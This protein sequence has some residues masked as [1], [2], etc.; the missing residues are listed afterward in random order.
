MRRLRVALRVEQ[1]NW[2]A[3]LEIK[4][5]SQFDTRHLEIALS[6]LWV[7]VHT[8]LGLAAMSLD[9]QWHYFRAAQFIPAW[10]G[11]DLGYLG[12]GTEALVHLGDSF[13]PIDKPDDARLAWEK[14]AREPRGPL[15]SLCYWKAKALENLGYP[16][17]AG[18]LWQ[19]MDRQA[20]WRLAMRHPARPYLLYLKSLA[21]FGL[22]DTEGAQS[23]FHA[24][25]G[26]G[27]TWLGRCR[28]SQDAACY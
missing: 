16:E 15:D 12:Y 24:A 10:L 17:A 5:N 14:A 26:A 3:A 4:M 2:N 28:A 19:R 18:R 8:R 7:V 21:C 1:E 25:Y 20:D 22:G 6:W 27:L 11:D 23:A 9:Q 13:L